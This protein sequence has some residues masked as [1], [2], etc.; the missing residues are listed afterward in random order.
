LNLNGVEGW[1][2]SFVFCLFEMRRLDDGWRLWWV[3][4]GMGRGMPMLQ[5]C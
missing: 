1:V 4:R 2:Q 3:A 5:R